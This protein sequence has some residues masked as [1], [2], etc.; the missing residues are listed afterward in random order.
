[1]NGPPRVSILMPFWNAARFLEE[2]VQSVFAQTYGGWELLLIDDGSTDASAAMARGWAAERPER[3]RYLEQP[4]RR[5]LGISAALNLGLRNARG[6]FV[7]LLDSDDVWLPR[8]LEQQVAIL[9]AR[10]GAAMLYGPVQ[11]WYGWT[12][13]PEDRR[14]DSVEPL[15]VEADTVI[16]P[17]R[18][19]RLNLLRQAPVPS[20]C[21]VL[22][23]RKA[24]EE[25]GGFENA[26]ARNHSDQAFYAKLLAREAVYASGKCWARYRRH[27]E[28]SIGRLRRRSGRAARAR[29]RFLN[30]AQAY[31]RRAGIDDAEL[32]QALAA[33]MARS[34]AALPA[35]ARL[36]SDPGGAL[37]DLARSA[38]RSVIPPGARDWL[39]RRVRGE[40]YLPPVGRARLG[41]LRRITPISR[42]WG[43]ERGLPVDRHYIEEFLALHADDVRGRVLEIGDDAYTRRFGGIAV[44]QSDIL[45]V[46]PGDRRATIT[47]NLD[48]AQDG[49]PEGRF[50]CILFTQT[51]Q[52]LYDARRAL[53]KLHRMLRP[54]GVLLATF[55]GI[56]AIGRPEEWGD[57][58]Y[59]SFTPVSA[60]R[61]FEEVFGGGRV[62]VQ[63]RGNVLAATA[64]LQ[65]LAAQDLTGE[66]LAHRDPSF[67]V[68]IG[69]RAVKPASERSGED[70]IPN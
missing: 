29:L 38:A 33:E 55:P 43:K 46:S 13:H 30:W 27:A 65:G 37:R 18:L 7:A 69:V 31:W 45:S 20:P 5:N 66:E 62:E 59:W 4:G 70:A 47:A 35:I 6:E 53:R 10:P 52:Y 44:E 64:F 41:D 61:L 56:T 8:K 57:S 19:L 21:S 3:V 42:R 50:D 48:E 51:L 16:E 26:F 22:L 40:A 23:R 17:P 68:S 11:Y 34:R 14:K 12:G 49:L 15:G 39:R 9:E 2:A 63:S 24:V 1:M 28:S 60:R 36:S 32:W 58:W 25:V 67:P 54:G